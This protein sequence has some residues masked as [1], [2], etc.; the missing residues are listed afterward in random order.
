MIKPFYF[1]HIDEIYPKEYAYRFCAWCGGPIKYSRDGTYMMH[2]SLDCAD[3]YWK[4]F[5]EVLDVEDLIGT[6]KCNLMSLGIKK[7]AGTWM[8]VMINKKLNDEELIALLD[9]EFEIKND[10]WIIKGEK[11]N[12]FT[13]T[14]FG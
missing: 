14:T 9:G 5:P 8:N 7:L 13:M 1:S 12:A 11:H 4:F 10:K 3:K 2:C 6:I